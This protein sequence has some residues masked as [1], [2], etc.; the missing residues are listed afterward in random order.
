MGYGI[1]I[2]YVLYSSKLGALNNGYLTAHLSQLEACYFKRNMSTQLR[3]LRLVNEQSTV[4]DQ[5][6]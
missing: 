2:V 3:G 5:S 1:I 4:L 6:E